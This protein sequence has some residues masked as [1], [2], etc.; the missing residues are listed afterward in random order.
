MCKSREQGGQR[1]HH[2]AS[3]A[4]AR[5][6]ADY[7]D[8]AGK[9]RQALAAHGAGNPKVDK[10][11]DQY[12]KAAA[13]REKAGILLASTNQGLAEVRVF[14]AAAANLDQ[15][16]QAG[17][18]NSVAA[19]GVNLR[20]RN[21]EVARVMRDRK[22]INPLKRR[23]AV[24]EAEQIATARVGVVGR[25]DLEDA[26]DDD[27]GD[28]IRPRA[29]VVDGTT[30]EPRAESYTVTAANGDQ[31]TVVGT[32]DARTPFR[33]EDI[34]SD[35]DVD[36]Y[37]SYGGSRVSRRSAVNWGDDWDEPAP[38]V[39]SDKESEEYADYEHYESEEGRS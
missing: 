20:E 25:W 39:A 22:T 32:G 4:F 34:D 38:T 26:D 9:Y 17:F 21:A 19:R 30:Y 3:R 18:W 33:D 24:E 31:Y 28:A 37:A 16:E 13:K 5:A 10:A 1:C 27:L 15:H 8:T 29:I 14:A 6:E 35:D 36:P 23:A 2:H 11:R 7:Q 12:L